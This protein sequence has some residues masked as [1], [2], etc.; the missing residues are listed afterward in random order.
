MEDRVVTHTS[1]PSHSGESLIQGQSMLKISK[2]LSKQTSW[3]WWHMTVIPALEVGKLQYKA[4]LG[5]NY[6]TLSAK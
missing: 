5:K 2:T 4:N 3:V 6:K 1:N